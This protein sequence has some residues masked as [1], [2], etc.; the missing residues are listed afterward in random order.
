MGVLE[1]AASTSGVSLP[2]E[3]DDSDSDSEPTPDPRPATKPSLTLT[4]D[5]SEYRFNSETLILYG[6]A[7][8]DLLLIYIA[9][10]V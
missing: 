9:L 7:L 10:K 6:V 8:A 4:I 1:V 5:G 2:S 3:N